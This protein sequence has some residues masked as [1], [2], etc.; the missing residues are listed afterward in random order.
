MIYYIAPILFF[1]NKEKHPFL[2]D[3]LVGFMGIFVLFGGVIVVLYNEIVMTNLLF[4]NIQTMV[5]H[6]I[7]VILGVFIV[8]WNRKTFDIS[9]FIKSIL[10]LAIYTILAIIVN[11]ILTPIADG[12]DMFYVNPYEESILPVINQIHTNVGYFAY[13]VV[14]L[15]IIILYGFITYFIEALSIN[16][17][18]IKMVFKKK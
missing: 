17:G 16:H 12:I 14:Y 8:T 4:I 15:S 18:K 5:H 13:L 9:T 7:Q 3:A 10:I 11:V 1:I 2:Y 6:G